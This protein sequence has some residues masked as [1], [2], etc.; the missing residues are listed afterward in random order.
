[1]Q[2]KLLNEKPE[3]T[4]VLIF[5][6]GDEVMQGLTDFAKEHGLTASRFT[7]I[8]AFSEVVFGYYDMERGDYKKIPVTEQVEVLSMLGDIALDNNQPKVHAHVVVGKADGHTR[9]GHLMEAYVEPTLEVVV[10]ES[11][12]YLQRE[13]DPATGLALIRL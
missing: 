12:S 2:S 9:G 10:V 7:A 11:P 3:K 5:D 4:Y 6:S 8:G 1:M 13:I